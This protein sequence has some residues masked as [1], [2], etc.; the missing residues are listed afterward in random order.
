MTVAGVEVASP[1]ELEYALQL[2]FEPKNIVFDR[3]ACPPISRPPCNTDKTS[4]MCVT[5]IPALRRPCATWSEHF[6]AV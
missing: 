6:P 3:S 4:L 1:V 5:G 2:G